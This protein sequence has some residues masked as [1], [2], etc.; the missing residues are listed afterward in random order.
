MPII[1]ITGSNGKTIIKEWLYQ[2][3]SPEKNIIRS[4]KSFNSQVGVPLSVWNIDDSHQLGIFEAGISK[5]GEMKKLEAIIKPSIGIFTILPAHAA[6][7]ESDLAKAKEKAVLFSN[8][9]NNFL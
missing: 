1:G 9:K 5:L 7:F 6:G 8:A 4:P 3:L 2:L